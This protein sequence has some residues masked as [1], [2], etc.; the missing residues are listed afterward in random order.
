MAWK[1]FERAKWFAIRLYLKRKIDEIWR[2]MQ[3]RYY[4]GG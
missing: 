4:N 1:P 2:L 3:E